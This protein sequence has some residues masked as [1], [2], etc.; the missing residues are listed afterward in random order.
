MLKIEQNKHTKSTIWHIFAASSHRRNAL[1]LAAL[2]VFL[3]V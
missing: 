2:L 3:A 1:L